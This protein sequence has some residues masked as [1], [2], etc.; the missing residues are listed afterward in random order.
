[1]TLDYENPCEGRELTIRWERTGLLAS[2][3]LERCLEGA[4][5]DGR[6]ALLYEGKALSFTDRLPAGA[7]AVQYRLTSGGQV[8]SGPRLAVRR[9]E[10]PRFQTG[11]RSLGKRSGAFSVPYLVEDSFPGASLSI[12]VKLDGTLLEAIEGLPSPV[13]LEATVGKETFAA[14]AA[15][16]AHTLSVTARNT[17]GLSAAVSF[18]FVCAADP[19]AGC[20]FYLLRDGAAVAKQTAALPF[21]D[22]G[23][24]GSH[25]YRVRVVDASGGFC[26]SNEVTV[27]SRIKSALLAPAAHPDRMLPLELSGG[28]PPIRQSKLRTDGQ[29]YL[30][31]GRQYAVLENGGQCS[32]SITLR[33]LLREEDYREICALF[34]AQEPVLYRDPYGNCMTA[35]IDALPAVFSEQGVELEIQLTRLCDPEE[36]Q[37]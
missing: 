2:Y 11:G 37:A 28:E 17:F 20:T 5:G 6:F 26:E 33:G 32:Q 25:R 10:P 3:R 35:A 24:A 22:Y 30:F 34:E 12:E 27:V 23:A 18:P 15:G 9:A 21:F 8:Q 14:L 36:A 1:M 13:Q 4:G 31:E 19:S 29:R 7:L 16:S